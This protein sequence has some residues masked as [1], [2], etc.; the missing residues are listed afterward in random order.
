[1]HKPKVKHKNV[2]KVNSDHCDKVDNID[3]LVS[4]EEVIETDSDTGNI[5]INSLDNIASYQ[6]HDIYHKNEERSR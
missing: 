1:M 6:E 2:T 3:T 5:F 4:K